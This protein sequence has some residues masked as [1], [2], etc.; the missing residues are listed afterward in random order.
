MFGD[1][2]CTQ[3]YRFNNQLHKNVAVNSF[4]DNTIKD[5]NHK[6]CNIKFL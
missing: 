4:G 3:K 6:C 2:F 5:T 1:I